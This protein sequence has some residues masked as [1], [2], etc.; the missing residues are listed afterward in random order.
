MRC[1]GGDSM[2]RFR[3]MFLISI[4][5]AAAAVAQTPQQVPDAGNDGPGLRISLDEAIR[6]S[7]RSNLGVEIQ[8][9]DFRATGYQ[10]RSTYGLFDPLAYAD[11]A[12]AI[13]SQPVTSVLFSPESETYSANYGIR[14][15]IP[16]GG[17]Y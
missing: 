3:S 5:T 13:N 11:A 2:T 4:F 15:T 6:T 16:T 7:V 8:A 12:A 9:L 14:Q 10:S 17:S 1:V